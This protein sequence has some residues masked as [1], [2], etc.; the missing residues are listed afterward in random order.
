[1]RPLIIEFVKEFIKSK[2][3]C[4][5]IDC[6]GYGSFV[7]QGLVHSFLAAILLGAPELDEFR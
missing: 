3:M 4:F 1:M 2:L 5:E 6:W 7:L